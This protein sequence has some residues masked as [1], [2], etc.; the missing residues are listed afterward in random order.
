M[1][2]GHL[3][4]QLGSTSEGCLLAARDEWSKR[5]QMYEAKPNLGKNCMIDFV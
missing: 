2:N 4:M 3:G 5:Q 1:T